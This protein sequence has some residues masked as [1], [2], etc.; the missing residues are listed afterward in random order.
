LVLYPNVGP[1][2][3]MRMQVFV[4]MEGSESICIFARRRRRSLFRRRSLSWE[5]EGGTCVSW[6][7]CDA[8]RD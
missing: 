3:P 1:S 5:G 2:L 4:R 7:G 6:V 8:R